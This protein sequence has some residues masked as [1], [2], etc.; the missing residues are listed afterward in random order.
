MVRVAPADATNLRELRQALERTDRDNGG[1]RSWDSMQALGEMWRA[2]GLAKLSALKD[3]MRDLLSAN[4][5]VG[6]ANS[7]K[8]IVFAHHLA[9][10][11]EAQKV[12]VNA[13]VGFV[14][15]DGSTSQPDRHTAVQRFQ[16]DPDVRLA[17]LSIKA[18]GQG[19]TMTAASTVVFAEM[20]WVPGELLQA[21]DRA[22]RI[23]QRSAVCIH[24]LIAPVRSPSKA[25][26]TLL[27]YSRNSCIPS[28][29]R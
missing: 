21:E 24:Y 9:V 6:E 16:N 18:A 5:E 4:D 10:L 2:A 19:L 1:E 17:I 23:G 7:G 15:I 26:L 28:R 20:T 29:A 3:Y 8:M 11:D 13:R 22:H 12:A 25:I 14:R 27:Q